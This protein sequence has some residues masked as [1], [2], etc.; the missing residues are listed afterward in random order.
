MAWARASDPVVLEEPKMKTL[1]ALK[2]E[3]RKITIATST[4]VYPRCRLIFLVQK[5][6]VLIS[7]HS[8]TG[9]LLVSLGSP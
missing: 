1:V 6:L 7:S 8:P 9:D 5:W 3:M 2:T 4:I